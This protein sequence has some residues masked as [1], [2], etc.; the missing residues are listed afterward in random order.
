MD[1]YLVRHGEPD[2]APDRIA[3]N[4]PEL[5][6]LGRD[7]ATRVARE[8]AS[9][10]A[11]DR[12]WVSPM[13]RAM[14]TSV[15]I[16]KSLGTEREVHDWLHEIAN[17]PQWDGSPA[18]E[19]DRWF[20]KVN[21]R[22]MDDLWEGLGPGGESFLDFHQRV[23]GGLVET[24]ASCGARPLKEGRPHLW[25]VDEPAIRVVVVAHAGANAVILGRL[26]GLPPV[27][28]EWERFR[29]PHSGVSRLTTIRIA[30]GW[31]FSLR[32]LGAVAHL[33]PSMVTV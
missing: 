7:Q 13:T 19:I 6:P 22:S 24:L 11:V 4:D 14:Q 33:D 30:H 10:G 12:L 29:Q 31:A 25:A 17:P 5:T 3:R 21:L 20:E 18:E 28:W 9:I 32:R 16:T 27:P 15:P 26:L 8:L 23:C 2:W 1:L